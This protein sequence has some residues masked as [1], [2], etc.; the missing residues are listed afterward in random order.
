MAV[1]KPKTYMTPKAGSVKSAKRVYEPANPWRNIKGQSKKMKEFGGILV[2]QPVDPYTDKERKSFRAAM[3]NGYVHRACK[4]QT[5][6]TVGRGYTTKIV[7]R[8][9]EDLPEDQRLL[10]ERGGVVHV[11]YWNREASPEEIKDFVDKL[12]DSKKMKLSTKYFNAKMSALEQGRAVIAITPLE[13]GENGQWQMPEELRFIRNEHLMRPVLHGETGE[14]KGVECITALTDEFN[15]MI[16]AERMIYIEQGFN[17]ELFS[18]H[19]GDSKVAR[20]ADEANALN[21]ILNQDYPNAAKY[22]WSKPRVFSV[23]IPPEE[24]GNEDA[25]LTAFTKK[26]NE[27]EGKDVA[28]TGPMGPEDPGVTLLAQGVTGSSDISGLEIARTG[29]IKEIISAFGIPAFMLAEG[30]KG[31]LGGN[32]NL[33]EIDS[34]LNTEIASDREIDETIIEQQLYDRILGVLFQTDDVD[35][36]P[37]KIVH[38]FNKPKLWT[39]LTPD[40]FNVLTGMV[41]QGYIDE[42]GLREFLGLE[43]FKKDTITNGGNSNPQA[44]QWAKNTWGK[45]NSPW[46]LNIQNTSSGWTITPTTPPEWG[47][48]PNSTGNW[49]TQGSNPSS[50]PISSWDKQGTPWKNK[51]NRSAV[52]W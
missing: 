26:L 38:K 50:T 35:S 11:P 8:E 41:Q 27:G 51:T 48:S 40:M 13:H 49:G 47:K 33:E 5:S 29:L 31:Q 24:F 4:I 19:Y 45:Q 25:V 22:V 7:P 3:D 46:S 44:D 10:F 42:D 18:D 32:A 12:C 43:E 39:L 37:V 17:Y 28:V 1:K 36:I 2:W 14:L 34:Y 20:V 6:F 23:P 16:P 15:N 21:V 52:T 9:E 30:D